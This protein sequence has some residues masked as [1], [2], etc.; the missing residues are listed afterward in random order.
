M[1]RRRAQ[2]GAKVIVVS[3]EIT[4]LANHKNAILLQLKAGTDTALLS[5]LMS[6]AFAE[7]LASSHKGL[8]ALK[9]ALVAEDEASRL[10]GVPAEKITEAAKAYAA[11]KHAVV[12]FGTGISA[13]EDASLQTLNLALIKGAGVMPLMLEANALGVML[14]GCTSDRGPGNAEVKKAGATYSDM[15]SGMKVLYV[16]GTVPDADFKADFMI[17]QASHTSALT[18]KADLVLPMTALYEKH[19]TI[20]TAYGTQK[21]FAQAQP[22]AADIKDGAEIAAEVSAAASKGKAFTAKDV[23]SLVKKVKAGKIGAGT[24]KPVQAAAA[25]P[26]GVS[27]TALLMAMNQGLLSGSAVIKVIEVKQPALR[28]KAAI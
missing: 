1:I 23:V 19:G 14:M 6:A 3:T 4:D 20:V 13:N 27:T 5:G 8:D 12:I 25:K 24:F 7:G 21:F 22:A 28:D 18:Q 26:Y 15:K 9:K 10:S 11:A 16:A 17:V 2:A